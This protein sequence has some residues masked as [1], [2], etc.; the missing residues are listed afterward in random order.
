VEVELCR[1]AG[2]DAF[3]MKPVPLDALLSTIAAVISGASGLYPD[4]DARLTPFA[5][6][7]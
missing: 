7:D 4:R 2:F 3:L 6:N 5:H 1:E